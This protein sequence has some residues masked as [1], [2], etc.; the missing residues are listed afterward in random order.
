MTALAMIL[1]MLPMSPGLGSG[2]EQNAPLGRAVIGGLTA[3]TFFTLFFVPV[4]YKLLKRNF[5]PRELH[6]R[7]RWPPESQNLG[8]NRHFGSR[9]KPLIAV[10]AVIAIGLAVYF[11]AVSPRIQNDRELN[12]A[13][14]AAG[15]RA[16]TV[17]E[18]TQTSSAPELVLPG[19]MQANQQTSIYARVDGYIARWYVDIG[20]HVEP[21]QVLADIE[22]PRSMQ[23]CAWP[24]PS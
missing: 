8:R 12:A 11:F 6:P 2:G 13:A 21:G 23:I 7:L 17:V 18:P 16:V 9:L 15:K 10:V 14:A 24:R 5:T 1:G 3:A 4:V 20:A 22:A 19:N